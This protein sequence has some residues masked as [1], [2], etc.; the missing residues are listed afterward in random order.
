MQIL[1]NIC[2]DSW[3]KLYWYSYTSTVLFTE[4]EQILA[5]SKYVWTLL[6]RLP[7][8]FSVATFLLLKVVKGKVNCA[9][10][11]RPLYICLKLDEEALWT[12]H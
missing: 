1:Q 2:G 10:E 4:A 9:T 7:C 8:R 6:S 5:T 3:D 12:E 11:Q